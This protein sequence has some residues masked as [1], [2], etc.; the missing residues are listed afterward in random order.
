MAK[1]RRTTTQTLRMKERRRRAAEPDASTRGNGASSHAARTAGR[2]PAPRSRTGQARWVPWAAIG[3]VVVVVAVM[4]VVFATR[5]QSGPAAKGSAAAV[6]EATGVP[7][8]TLEQVGVPSDVRSPSRLPAG[9]PP[10]TSEGKPVITYIGAEYCPFCAAE[11]WP[12][13]VALSRFG[14][15]SGLETTSSAAPPEVYPNTPTF[16]FHGSNY[17]SDVLVFSSAETQTRDRTP[18]DT[19]SAQQQQLFGSYDTASYVGSNGAIPFIMIGNKYAWVG[20]SYDLSVLKGLS[21]N[22]IA[23]QLSDPTSAVA[24]AVDGAANNI[25]AMICQTT[26]DQPGTVCSAPYIQQAQARLGS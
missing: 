9:T 14:T 1:K 11:R 19:L 12:M 25:T 21:F 6:A 22:E 20:A 23:N 2:R 15:F 26:G 10:V 7:V 24:K 8:S 16:S 17:A 13:V 5:N 3:A 18:L 4:V